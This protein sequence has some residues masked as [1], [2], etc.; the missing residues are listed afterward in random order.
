MHQLELLIKI[1]HQ[2]SDPM[3]SSITTNFKYS[4]FPTPEEDLGT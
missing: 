3:L 2:N 4:Y 1:Q